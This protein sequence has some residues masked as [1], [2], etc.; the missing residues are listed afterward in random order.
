V[1]GDALNPFELQ[2]YAPLQ[3][4]FDL[5]AIGRRSPSHEV[6]EIALPTVLLHAAS[7]VAAARPVVR[8]LARR[9]APWWDP[10][11]LFGLP[12]AVRGRPIIHA[13]ETVLPVT[14]QAAKLARA[15]GA[16]LVLTCWETIPFRYDDD[17]V[18]HRRK[19]LVKE[20]ATHYLAVTSR[21][22]DALV[23]EGVPGEKVSVVPAA[24]DCDRFGPS[25]R[26]PRVCSLWDVPESSFVVLYVGRLI[27]E[28]G[29]TELVRAFAQARLDDAYLVFVG[30]GTQQGRIR[31][32]AE[33]HGIANRVKVAG[34]AS[35][36]ILP[37]IYA[38]ADIVVAPSL[39]TPYWEE[40]FG[41]VLVEAMACARPLVTTLSGAIPEVVGNAAK[42]VAPYDLGALANAIRCL[43]RD[44]PLRM[45]LG[46][47]ARQRAV[48]RYSVQ[49]VAPQIAALYHATLD[50]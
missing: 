21:S 38:S 41:M 27:M 44:E 33:A 13:A 25:G 1:R 11:Y 35:Y 30:H 2:A 40:Q 46:T 15:E 28:K 26:S 14:A 32:A 4:E 23:E 3:T 36:A 6:G 20:V 9:L 7:E 8:R 34:A 49:V 17:P 31:Y 22:R 47:A 45:A 50:H 39:P 37:E 5:M 19:R 18:L 12:A 24:V 29:V 42:L 43:G 16:K 48:D 10:D